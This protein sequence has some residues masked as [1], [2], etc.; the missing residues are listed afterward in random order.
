MSQYF[1]YDYKF[2]SQ[3]PSSST[4]FSPSPG[5]ANTS[6]TSAGEDF[7]E[8]PPS[9]DSEFL[10]EKAQTRP[11]ATLDQHPAVARNDS[12]A[13]LPALALSSLA[14]PEDVLPWPRAAAT[15]PA[16]S[17][18]NL[19]LAP[20]RLS[21]TLNTDEPLRSSSAPD[22]GQYTHS[23]SQSGSGYAPS[24]EPLPASA[25]HPDKVSPL[26]GGRS[27]RSLL[28][29]PPPPF[30]RAPPPSDAETPFAP[31][32]VPALGERFLAD[33]F[34]AVLPA[35]EDGEEAHPFA[36]HDVREA[37]W[38]HFL[39]DIKRAAGVA[40]FVFPLVSVAIIPG[41]CGRVRSAT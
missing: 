9:Y 37:D 5:D 15:V 25:P 41:A 33:G 1:P 12:S 35:M 6:S 29:P 3:D 30:C 14:Q 2:T 26:F 27:V 22:L 28:N 19:R 36:T 8:P 32:V 18:T 4:F 31:L 38:M 34:P 7:A 16:Q 23:R 24:P 40:G 17:M 20:L 11:K 13:T 39:T 10:V 21:P